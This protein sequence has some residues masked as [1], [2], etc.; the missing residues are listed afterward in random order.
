MQQATTNTSISIEENTEELERDTNELAEKTEHNLHQ[1]SHHDNTSLI[2]IT[3][4]DD[5]TIIG[6]T[7]LKTSETNSGK[8]NYI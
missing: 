5:E 7:T 6:F 4:D 1:A 3:D 8:D 2:Y